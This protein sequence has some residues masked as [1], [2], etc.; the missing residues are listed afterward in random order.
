MKHSEQTLAAYVTC[1]TSPDLL[2]PHQNKTMQH[3][4]KTTKI[5]KIYLCNIGEEGGPDRLIP[6]IRLEPVASHGT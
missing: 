5:L 2:L 3:T 6:V 1:A 4:F